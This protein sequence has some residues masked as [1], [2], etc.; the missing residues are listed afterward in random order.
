VKSTLRECINRY[1]PPTLR[2]LEAGCVAGLGAILHC[3]LPADRKCIFQAPN[4][5]T[6]RGAGCLLWPVAFLMRKKKAGIS[7]AWDQ[8]L[9]VIACFKITLASWSLPYNTEFYTEVRLLCV[10]LNSVAVACVKY[11]WLE[12]ENGC[13]LTVFKDVSLIILF[14]SMHVSPAVESVKGITTKICGSETKRTRI[15]QEII[16]Q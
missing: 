8:P 6:S 10:V 1:F 16:Y 15:K 4:G 5:L 11:G 7:R 2:D 12:W 9:A 14:N 3:E 13:F